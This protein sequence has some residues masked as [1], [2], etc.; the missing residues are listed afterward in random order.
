[1][2]FLHKQ[3]VEKMLKDGKV[4]QLFPQGYSMYPL[5]VPNRDMAVIAPV[6][7]VRVGEVYLYRRKN[8]IL[9]LHR[10]CKKTKDGL[11]FVG[12]NQAEIEGPLRESQLRGQMVGVLRKGKKI[13]TNNVFYILYSRVWLFLRPLRPVISKTIHQI[14]VLCREIRHGQ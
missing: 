3:D 2:S 1:M 7:E 4:V 13:A 10:L 9:V 5:F 8:S 6:R 12:D 14:K 11:Y